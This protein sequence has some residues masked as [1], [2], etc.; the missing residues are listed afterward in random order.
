MPRTDP[1]SHQ[2]L[3]VCT[4]GQQEYTARDTIEAAIFR[5]E[6]DATWKR[7]LARVAAEKQAEEQDL[8]PDEEAISAAA[9]AF[10]Y[11]HDL[12]TAEETEAWLENRGLTFDDFSDYFCRQYYASVLQDIVADEVEYVSA[13]SALRE[14]FVAELILSGELERMMSSLMWRLAARCAETDRSPDL[15][16][17]D[18]RTFF[19][20]NRI[21]PAQLANWLE[22]LGRDLKWF[23]EM[24]EMEAAYRR[25]CDKLLVPR[26]RQRE[27]V[28]LRLLL[29]RFETEVIELESRDAAMEAQFCVREDG[30]SM[31]EV[32]IEGRYPYEQVSLVFEDLPTD[33]QQALLRVSAGDVLEP[34]PRGDGFE[35]W[36]LVK[37]VE[38]ESDDPSVKARIDQR[39]LER[40][41]SELVSKYI[42]RS[43]D[44]PI[45]VE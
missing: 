12:I 17:L 23:N 14:L 28:T 19:E 41:F 25:C 37:K 42:Q 38:P 27:L 5:G 18:E 24:L 6:L 15:I 20:R 44:G 29:T 26:A 45:S 3:V 43:L 30:M 21:K 10:R 39:L 40:H 2:D 34:F 7:F 22:R 9:E 36:R 1:V 8:D 35:L 11:D 4:C 31:E 16:A 33:S 13:S 32:A